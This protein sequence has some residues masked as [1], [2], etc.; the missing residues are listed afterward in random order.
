MFTE[1]RINLEMTGLAG[2]FRYL[3][4]GKVRDDFVWCQL[5]FAK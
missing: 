5:S 4:G 1:R 2:Y 3:L